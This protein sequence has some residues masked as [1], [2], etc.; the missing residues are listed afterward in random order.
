MPEI[1][2]IRNPHILKELRQLAIQR[3]IKI[4]CAAV[5]RILKN[6][7]G[8]ELENGERHE[9]G[10]LLLAAGHWNA[11]LAGHA[12][13]P[14]ELFPVRGQMLLFRLPPGRLP[15]ILLSEKGYL[16]PRRDGL[17]LAGSTLEPN[18][19]DCRPTYDGE[20]QLRQMAETLLPE[21]EGQQPIAQ[22][23]GIRPGCIRPEPIIRPLDDKQS[24][25]LVGGHY[26]NGLVAAPAT[27]RL[28]ADLLQ[29][30]PAFV[31]PKPYR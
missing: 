9:A 7:V 13:A 3:G 10:Q 28:V 17:V 8:V 15:I 20:R 4:E 29:G 26:R 1:A 21:L 12:L 22:W 2:S 11:Q 27:A 30:R 5:R 16:I 25:W 19:S 24:C 31:D 14:G 23:A 6:R 18:V